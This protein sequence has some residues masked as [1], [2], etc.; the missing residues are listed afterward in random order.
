[1]SNGIAGVTVRGA[2]VSP[3]TVRP[4]RAQWVDSY[5]CDTDTDRAAPPSLRTL[6]TKEACGSLARQTGKRGGARNGVGVI[7]F[8][9]LIKRPPVEPS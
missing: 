3:T 4:K 2:R 1:M 5:T 7:I 6:C 9:H 8:Y